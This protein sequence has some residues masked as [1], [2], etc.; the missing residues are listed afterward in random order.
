MAEF[1]VK[2]QA[3]L[4]N[5][6]VG[7]S[8]GIRAD[9]PQGVGMLF[10]GLAHALDSGVKE[11]DRN[12]KANIEKDIFD[13]VDAVQGE[14]GV[15]DATDMQADADEKS[16]R[17]G[18]IGVQRANEQLQRLQ[19]AYEQGN[20]KESHYWARMNN[21][22]RQLRGKYPGYRSEIDQMV[23][24]VTG[25]RPA[26]ALRAALFDEWRAEASKESSLSKLEDWAIKNGRLPVDY[27]QR[28]QENNPYTQTELAAYVARKQRDE[29]ERSDRRAALAEN[30]ERGTA[31]TKDV[32]KAFRTEA[33]QTVTT[34]LQDLSL[35][36]I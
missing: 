33:S 7:L 29:A 26:N 1:N 22:V 30:A 34:I 16:F 24:S 14:F 12:V 20:L 13:E 19:L 15:P 31:T 8:E 35:I 10:E 21:M 28:K 5:S 2:P 27:Y 3:Q 17:T 36:H 18:P 9:R 11:A 25:A 4:P 32:E 6:Y 23:A